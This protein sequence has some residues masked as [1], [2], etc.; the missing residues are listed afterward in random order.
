LGK[1]QSDV[2]AEL[3]GAGGD[4]KEGKPAKETKCEN[5]DVGVF[6]QHNAGSSLACPTSLSVKAFLLQLHLYHAKVAS[7]RNFAPFQRYL[8][9]FQRY[10]TPR[11]RFR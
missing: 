2:E 7:Q 3:E 11:Q 8:T 6:F 9:P 1:L 5:D 4:K 10:P